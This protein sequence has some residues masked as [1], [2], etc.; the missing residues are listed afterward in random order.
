MTGSG[1]HIPKELS[2]PS[3]DFQ[4]ASESIGLYWW[5]WNHK[6]RRMMVSHGL[7]KRLGIDPET[8]DHTIESIYMKVHPEDIPRN[9]VRIEALA[10]GE[11]GLYELE[12]RVKDSKGGWKWY[13]NRGTVTERDKEGHP[14]IIG[15]IT[16]DISGEFQHLLSM[17]EEKDKFEFIFR[18]STEPALILQ[19]KE[20]SVDRIRDVN[21]AAIDYFNLSSLDLTSGIP[22]Q[23]ST[24]E[25]W[26]AE[27]NL[28][29]QIKA[30][31]VAKLERKLHVEGRGKRWLEFTAYEFSLTSE[32]LILIMVTDRT[33]RKKTEAALRE[34][35]KLYRT[36]FEA[37]NDR[38]GLFSTDGKPILVNNAFYESIGYTRDEYMSME[39]EA[40]I[41]P[42]DRQ[43]LKREGKALFEQG[44]SGHEYRVKHKEG[45]YLHMSSKVVLIPG[46]HGEPDLV[47][48][49]IRDI[50]DRKRFIEELE[51][52]KRAA[53]ESDQLK[54]AF[55]ANMSHEI[56]TPMNSIVGFSN[57]LLNDHLEDSAR[58][59]YVNR[60]VRNSELL[61][62]LISDIIDLAKIESGQLP[63]VYGK[64]KISELMNDMRQYAQD[65][66]DRLDGKRL[67][68]I[69][70]QRGEDKEME[71]DVIRI[72]QVMKNL[73]N[74]AIKFTDK[75]SV[76][77]GAN[78]ALAENRVQFY[79]RDTGIGID[80]EHFGLIFDQ[81]RQ[82]DG[83]NTRR[84]GGTG[85]G[86][87]I[88][89][90]LVYMMGGR[91]WVESKPGEGALFQLELPLVSEH[92]TYREEKSS[93]KPPDGSAGLESLSILVVEDEPDS[94]DL[95]DEMLTSRGHRIIKA[96][97]GFEALRLL[98]H[99]VPPNMILMDVEMPVMNGTE[100][101]RIMKAR[102]PGL[103]VVAQ[104]AH[105]LL[106]DRERFLKEGFDEYLAKPINAHQLT[107]ILDSLPVQK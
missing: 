6:D 36:L 100:T 104:S 30:N 65:E 98:E 22:A 68:V 82:V 92:Y 32:D 39:G 70:E 59:T 4:A 80:S 45:Y 40:E 46:E 105:A 84:F 77:I 7:L 73:I 106:G 15:G 38:I 74:N 14:L 2:A 43:R 49:I 62:T 72:A 1:F 102:H 25:M 23:F 17:V 81:F 99:S 71:T 21:Q 76:T 31:G 64:L 26:E 93:V 35:E 18:N 44:F 19:L 12:F 58:K 28:M 54:S 97:T 52:A 55:L 56:R 20:G 61:L 11:T 24:E 90:N 3:A 41:H 42:E 47:L 94:A 37:A 66:L 29:D 8:Y 103:Y 63:L 53:E 107:D 33:A 96:N 79:V 91:I 89:K 34:T 50:T 13:Y 10:S 5:Y 51:A 85:L 48:F 27:K 57:L 87:A 83:S 95:L 67:E 9:R 69:L 101:L 16:I 60:I 75:G 78:T 86:L 88:C